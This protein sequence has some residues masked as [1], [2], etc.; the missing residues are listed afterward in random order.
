MKNLHSG[1]LP[2]LGEACA[3]FGQIHMTQWWNPTITK[4]MCEYWESHNL[5]TEKHGLRAVLEL[6][7]E[8]LYI[9]IWNCVQH[10]TV[11]AAR[12]WNSL[13]GVLLLCCL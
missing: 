12:K 10:F 7:S 11:S 13:M 3:I 4:L 5:K 2:S 8:K 1:W 6:M 9:D